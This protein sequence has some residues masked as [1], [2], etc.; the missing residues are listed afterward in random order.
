MLQTSGVDISESNPYPSPSSVLAS[1]SDLSCTYVIN[2]TGLSTLLSDPALIPARGVLQYYKRPPSFRTCILVDDGPVGSSTHPVYAI[3][4][5]DLVAV[6]GTYLENDTETEVREEEREMLEL[7]ASTLLPGYPD[8]WEKV[9]EWA[10]FRPVREEGVKIGVNE[11]LTKDGVTWIDNY[12]HGGSGWTVAEG[13][14]DD[15]G[16]II[17]GL[18]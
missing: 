7:N 15:V 18:T 9:G 12:G 2:C 4:R 10:G 16:K 1:A 13:C 11:D 17:K 14:A 3:P 8:G 5:G 6:G